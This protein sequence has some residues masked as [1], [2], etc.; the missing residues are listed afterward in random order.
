MALVATMGAMPTPAESKKIFSWREQGI[1]AAHPV[2]ELDTG[3]LTRERETRT[4]C[5]VYHMRTVRS[6]SFGQLIL[7]AI[8]FLDLH[9]RPL[10]SS[11]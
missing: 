9:C 4:K 2:E 10:P 11:Q 8:S 3:C 1:H 6:S 5:V 7:D